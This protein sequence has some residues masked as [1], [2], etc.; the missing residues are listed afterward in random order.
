MRALLIASCIALALSLTNTPSF[1]AQDKIIAVVNNDI[2]TQKDYDDFLNFMRVQLSQEYDEEELEEKIASM[3]TD[4]LDRLIEDRL[5]LQEA[6]RIKIQPDEAKVKARINDLKKQYETD[7]EF[8]QALSRQGLVQADLEKRIRDQLLMFTVVDAKVRSKVIVTPAEITAYY[9][10]HAQ[11]FRSPLKRRVSYVL[12]DSKRVAEEVQSALN[13]SD[14]F[15]AVAASFNL[16]PGTLSAAKDQSLKKEIEEVVFRLKLKEV[17]SPVAIGDSYYIFR[18]EELI[19]AEVLSLAQAQEHIRGA[20]Y[21][22]KLK[23]IMDSWIQ[24]M[25]SRSYIKISP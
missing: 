14:D 8:H 4:L 2:I 23:Q 12:C 1:G 11:D 25:R 19:P 15:A 13:S 5:I 20:L 18:L 3:K 6:M 21:E 9:Q 24:E 7:A 16:T 10:E 22:E 17:S